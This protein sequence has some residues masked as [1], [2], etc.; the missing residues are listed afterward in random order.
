M[1]ISKLS[2][3]HPEYDADTMR[4]YQCLFE[5][6]KTLR[7]NIKDFIPQ[8]DVEPDPLYQ[9]RIKNSHYLNYT[10]RIGN[11]FASWLFS[12]TLVY[13]S[14]RGE[15]KDDEFY[16]EFKEDCD[17]N[18]TDFDKFLR[19]RFVEA[20]IKQ[21]SY[22]LVDFPELP[23]NVLELTAADIDLGRAVLRAI[24]TENVINW[25]K[26]KTGAFVWLVTYECCE[27]I[28]DI[29][30]DVYHV[31]TWTQYYANGDTRRWELRVKEDERIDPDKEVPEIEPPGNR[32]GAIPIVEMCLPVELWLLNN[33]SDPQTEHFQAHTAL[34]W[35]IKRTCY[36]MAVLKLKNANKSP[37]LG[38]G[39]FLTIGVE[40]DLVWASPPAQHFGVIA[41]YCKS[42]KEE[43]HRVSDQMAQALSEGSAANRQTAE[44]KEHDS[45]STGIV[46]KAYGAIV[47]HVVEKTMDMVSAGRGDADYEWAISGMDSFKMVSADGLATTALTIQPLQVRSPTFQKEL[48]KKLTKSVLP[49]LSQKLKE[50]IDKEIDENLFDEEFSGDVIGP[51]AEKQEREDERNANPPQEE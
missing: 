2:R 42:L 14:G 32:L 6:G 5:G 21:R 51:V 31:H 36:A 1:K 46:L 33:L 9:K 49:D 19:D 8:N 20:L 45:G 25:K 24:P 50:Q 12:S 4:M 13:D 38:S 34:S 18:G 35:S 17:G 7:K 40:E 26:T 15:A 39:Y 30:S 10:G 37:R 29:E 27:E 43:I 23:E 41:D 28:Q 48:Q 44:A 3:K 16:S 22:F 11:F 47:R